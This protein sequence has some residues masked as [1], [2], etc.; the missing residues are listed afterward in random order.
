MLGYL[1]CP[2]CPNT[3]GMN[4]G[5]RKLAHSN[6]EFGLNRNQPMK[7]FTLTGLC[8]MLLFNW[9]LLYSQTFEIPVAY[10]SDKRVYELEAAKNKEY[11]GREEK[12]RTGFH[13]KVE[14]PDPLKYHLKIISAKP[15]NYK[16]GV[17]AALSAY[18]GLV[19]LDTQP[20]SLGPNIPRV[21]PPD[22]FDE[23]IEDRDS[24]STLIT[25][26]QTRVSEVPFKS[27][28][29][30]AMDR[31]FA[32][33]GPD[34]N[35]IISA[36]IQQY[37][38]DYKFSR[39]KL[40]LFDALVESYELVRPVIEEYDELYT[41]VVFMDSSIHNFSLK[42]AQMDPIVASVVDQKLTS[43]K[44]R[45]GVSSTKALIDAV[46]DQLLR[47]NALNETLEEILSSNIRLDERLIASMS[48]VNL[49]Q[50]YIKS[51]TNIPARLSLLKSLDNPKSSIDSQDMF[52]SKGADATRV[53]LLLTNRFTKDTLLAQK[54]DAPVYQG[55]DW[56]FSTG[57][58]YNTLWQRNFYL[59]QD[60]RTINGVADTMKVIKTENDFEGDVAFAAFAHA[61]F[62][63]YAARYGLSAGIGVGFTDGKPRYLLG[64]HVMFAQRQSIGITA[65]LAWARIKTLSDK[66][67]DNGIDPRGRVS[68]STTAVATVERMKMGVYFGVVWNFARK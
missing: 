20:R 7:H 36:E 6:I 53:N 67:S 5:Q 40:I 10:D 42:L 59:E 8:L 43:Y 13:F 14:N 23:V 37:T 45:Y 22:G 29:I 60:I 15:I 64:G 31:G 57:F 55:V 56:E 50:R 30:A 58:I 39:E 62:R 27:D 48:S 65:G 34:R 21:R 68:N 41:D 2:I 52:F 24:I 16:V 66:V 33:L 11:W 4:A 61:S 28:F 46:N 51:K 47:L 18:F 38:A 35:E 49:A 17:P 44:I 1:Y 63:K 12:D 25:S 9:T 26:F 3:T 19:N 54:I 32:L